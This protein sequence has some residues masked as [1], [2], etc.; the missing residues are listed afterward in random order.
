MQ[1][2]VKKKCTKSVVV[3]FNLL[4]LVLN[5]VE[6]RKP[7]SLT[8]CWARTGCR[9]CDIQIL[10][11]TGLHAV[12]PYLPP[13][14]DGKFLRSGM[15]TQLCVHSN[16]QHMALLSKDLSDIGI[17]T[18]IQASHCPEVTGCGAHPTWTF[19]GL[20]LTFEPSQE[21]EEEARTT[22]TSLAM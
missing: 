11:C 7:L 18:S 4:N 10:W 16:A 9:A 12:L 5:Q 20:S 22:T 6:S 1:F 2:P 13:H 17:G 14:R 19:S 8:E 3:S 21:G 15:D